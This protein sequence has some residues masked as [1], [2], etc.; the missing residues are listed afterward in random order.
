MIDPDPPR[1]PDD[2]DEE[3]QPVPDEPDE[4]DE[5]DESDTRVQRR[6]TSFFLSEHSVRTWTV[7]SGIAAVLGLLIAVLTSTSASSPPPQSTATDAPDR[8]SDL[9]FE[10]IEEF[11]TVDP[12]TWVSDKTYSPEQMKL[13]PNPWDFNKSS[14]WMLENGFI[15]AGEMNY[16]VVV[17]APLGGAAILNI[18]G[19]VVATSPP[20]VGT[21]AYATPQ[22]SEDDTRLWINLDSQ[23]T[24]AHS[25]NSDGSPSGDRFFDG[26]HYRLAENEVAVFYITIGSEIA[27]HEWILRV[28]YF[29]NGETKSSELSAS[30][31]GAPM[32]ISGQ[33]NRC[34]RSY[35]Y[36]DMTDGWTTR[37]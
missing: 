2:Q 10:I 32:R 9:E 11:E 31:N 1:P 33:P 19:N 12:F 30:D 34:R 24:S 8:S 16:R 6:I 28:D 23:S 7:I 5:E 4:P 20:L 22:S 29:L 21:C 13:G 35:E 15:R 17:R 36:L 27:S 26:K 37:P 14:K 18:S 25:V 3:G